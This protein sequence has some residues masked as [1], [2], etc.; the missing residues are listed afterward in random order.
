MVRKSKQGKKCT[1]WAVRVTQDL[2]SLSMENKCFSPSGRLFNECTSICQYILTTK[3]VRPEGSRYTQ[4]P[5]SFHLI[6]MSICRPNFFLGEELLYKY[7]CIWCVH[8]WGEFRVFLMCHLG[9]KLFQIATSFKNSYVV[10]ILLFGNVWIRS[11]LNMQYFLCLLY[12]P[13]VV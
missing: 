5:V 7:M 6:C 8:G 13:F 1:R 11:K 10:R 9:P 12:N 4:W 3:K 2:Q